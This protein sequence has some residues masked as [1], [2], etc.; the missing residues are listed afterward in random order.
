MA[1]FIVFLLILSIHPA[2]V[3][4][5][6]AHLPT[7]WSDNGVVLKWVTRFMSQWKN[8]DGRV[9]SSFNHRIDSET[10][11]TLAKPSFRLQ[12][13][14][15]SEIHQHQA[16]DRQH[17]WEE[18]YRYIPKKRKNIYLLA[19]MSLHAVCAFVLCWKG[20]TFGAFPLHGTARYGSVQLTFGGF[21]TG[22]ST[23]YF[24]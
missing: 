17:R 18:R 9:K 3:T 23:W 16:I 11:L 1:A 14:C 20:D 10:R 4:H 13:C 24:F 2:P 5:V 7:T 8:S 15:S 22:Y 21:S 12:L 6:R 19:L